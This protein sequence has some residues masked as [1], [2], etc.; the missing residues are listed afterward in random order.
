MKNG[1]VIVECHEGIATITLNR[2]EVKNA[3]NLAMH[4]DLQEAFT[5]AG[6]DPAVKVIILQGKDG[7]FSSGA[8]LKSIPID[9]FA[10]FD[11]GDY[12]KDTY[13]TLIEIIEE[14]DKP[15]IAYLNGISVG[16]GLSIALAC[17]F[18]YAHSDAIL[19]VSFLKIA[20]VPD[21]GASYYLPRIVGLQKALE[22]C[23]G[24]P[25]TAEEA[26]CCGLINSIGC[27]LEF[28]KKLTQVPVTTFGL[29]KKNMRNSFDKSLTEVLNMEIDTQRK[30][31][32]SPEHM[33]AIQAFVKKVK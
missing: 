13:N 29:M 5:T 24:E 22:L 4:K 21:A 9:D 6:N 2:P 12:L 8:D 10:S 28:A 33:Q 23:L 16:A 20:L 19:G 25:I 15:I 18:R 7:A 30:A 11:H 27:P 32:K 3:I 31:G 26:L 17:D 1:T 14:I